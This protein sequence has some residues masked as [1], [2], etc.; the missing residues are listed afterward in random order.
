MA[1]PHR[2]SQPRALSA[3]VPWTSPGMG[4][5]QLPGQPRFQCLTAQSVK[6]SLVMSS[7]PGVKP[8]DQ[9]VSTGNLPITAGMCL[10]VRCLAHRALAKEWN[11]DATNEPQIIKNTDLSIVT[12]SW[13]REASL[14]WVCCISHNI[15]P[16]HT[17]RLCSILL[18]AVIFTCTQAQRS[19][20]D[21]LPSTRG[22]ELYLYVRIKSLHVEQKGS[23]CLPPLSLCTSER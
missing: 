6:K 18:C 13:Q 10:K 14:L 5:Q 7:Y 17:H 4:T 16:M 20:P 12:W 15:T 19:D 22:Q 23:A 9:D 11:K 21:V 3:V 1:D 8:A 2:V